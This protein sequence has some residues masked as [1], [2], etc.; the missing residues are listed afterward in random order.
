[1]NDLH[2]NILEVQFEVLFVNISFERSENCVNEWI[3]FVFPVTSY[4]FHFL[5]LKSHS[6]MYSRECKLQPEY[7]RCTFFLFSQLRM[8]HI[9]QVSTILILNLLSK[10]RICIIELLTALQCVCWWFMFFMTQFSN[11]QIMPRAQNA[12]AYVNAGFLIQLQKGT[13]GRVVKKP[14]IVYGGINPYF[15][16]IPKKIL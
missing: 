14:T 2:Y 11:F 12:H 3:L 9:K 7:V 8:L 10:E 6:F 5:R 1:M 16:S 13:K 4:I 15:V